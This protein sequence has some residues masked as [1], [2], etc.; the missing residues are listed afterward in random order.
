MVGDGDALLENV[1]VEAAAGGTF[2]K[3]A[4]MVIVQA[5]LAS[6]DFGLCWSAWCSGRRC[7][8]QSGSDV[9]G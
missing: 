6:G 2:S 1:V 9:V 5:A 7:Q 3:S 4:E 8:V